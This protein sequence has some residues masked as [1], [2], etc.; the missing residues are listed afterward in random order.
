MAQ[1]NT[2]PQ[3]NTEFVRRSTMYFAVGIALVIGVYMGTLLPS[4]L[5][6]D[7]AVAPQGAQAA[8]MPA[9]QQPSPDVSKQ[10]LQLEQALLKNPQDLD[11]L[12][13]LGNL[14]FD[15]HNHKGAIVAYEKA[16]A[17][18]PDNADVLTD[19]GVM[20]RDEKMYDKAVNAFQKAIQVNPKHQN[21]L[22]N[23]GVVLFFDMDRKEEGRTAWRELLAINPNAKTPDGKSLRELIERR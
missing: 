1:K 8:N 9:A 2:Q 10:I 17:I 3:N 5:R 16:L 11:A 21:A 19:L 15:T 13:H 22:F 23:K 4:V 20:Y 6:A 7:Q 14:Y 12:I 18:K